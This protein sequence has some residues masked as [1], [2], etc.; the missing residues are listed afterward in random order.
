MTNSNAL[1]GPLLTEG[2]TKKIYAYPDDDT[3]VYMVG[4]DQ[5]TAGDGARRNEIAGKSR[6]STITTANVFRL[7]NEGNIATHFVKKIDDTTLLVKRCDMLPIEHVQRRIATG[8]YLKRNPDVSEGTRF[9]PVLIE[10][11]L[12][13]DARHDPQIWPKDIIELGLASEAEIAWMAQEGRRVFDVLERAWNSADVMLVDLKIEF[14]RDP[15][16]NLMVADVI[17]NDS[18]RL[19]PGGDKSRMLDKQVYRNLQDVTPAAL[20]D[21]ADRY[22]LVADLTG[23][24]KVN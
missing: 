9:D 16:G 10:T 19:W 4:K 21:I 22:A 13:D 15:Q 18:W 14:G 20:Q 1:F 3:L 23:K 11:F 7:L 17:D 6:L 2:K 24:L 8:S 5:I 12:K